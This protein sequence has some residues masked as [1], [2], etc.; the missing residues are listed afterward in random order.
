MPAV[1]SS[2]RDDDEAAVIGRGA[3]EASQQRHP[4][5]SSNCDYTS[6]MAQDFYAAFGVGEDAKHIS[7]VDADGVALASIKALHELVASQ[8]KINKDQSKLIE[9]LRVHIEK[10][11]SHR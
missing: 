5:R 2:V 8:Q 7:S 9:A 10:L 4:H 3:D 11:E 6:K 1:L